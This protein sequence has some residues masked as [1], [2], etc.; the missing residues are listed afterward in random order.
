[1]MLLHDR[2]VAQPKPAARAEPTRLVV[3]D[4]LKR[5]SDAPVAAAH[6]R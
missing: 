3:G 2:F 1:V 6:A 4:S 5:S